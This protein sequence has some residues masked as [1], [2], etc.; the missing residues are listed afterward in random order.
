MD[1]QKLELLKDAGDDPDV[2]HGCVVI[3]R[4]KETPNSVTFKAGKG[5]G[6]VS[7]PGLPIGVG[8]PAINP[9]ATRN[10]EFYCP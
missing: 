10:D 7:M 1:G 4:V 6:T 2:T 3:A 9:K 5:V 8:E